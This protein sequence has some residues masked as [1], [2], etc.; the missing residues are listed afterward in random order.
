[1]LGHGMITEEMTQEAKRGAVAY[2]GS[3]FP[4]KLPRKKR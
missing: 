1:M 3:Y 2:L 4:A